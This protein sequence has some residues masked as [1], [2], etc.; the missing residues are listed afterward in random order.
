MNKKS[1]KRRV[2]LHASFVQHL[3]NEEYEGLL[4]TIFDFLDEVPFENPHVLEVIENAKKH[5][6]ALV[7]LGKRT[8]AHDTTVQID[9]MAEEC[10]KKL[11]ALNMSINAL[12]LEGDDA[13]RKSVEVAYFWIRTER[14]DLSTWSKSLQITV[15]RRL[16]F[17]VQSKTEVLN[18][19]EELSLLNRF[20]S[21][22]ALSDKIAK[23]MEFRTTDKNDAWQLRDNRRVD[24]YYDLRHMLLTLEGLSNMGKADSQM[25]FDVCL[26]IHSKL[27]KAHAIMR[28]RC[29]RAENEREAEKEEVIATD[30]DK[31]SEN[32]DPGN[33]DYELDADSPS[34]E[35]S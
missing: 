26:D 8:L 35:E 20:E 27:S 28:S 4:H 19:L 15:V 5:L 18:A 21:I 29:T 1:L 24:S 7:E 2:K 16:L 13:T 12:I 33:V 30:V 25:Y 10:R 11:R 23:L 22:V 3:K 17:E 31:T 9:E 32:N 34:G 14:K 6:E